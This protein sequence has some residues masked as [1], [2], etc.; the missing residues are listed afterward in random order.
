[1]TIQEQM[2]LN[3]K[4]FAAEKLIQEIAIAEKTTVKDIADKLVL[5][6]EILKKIKK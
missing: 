6:S 5:L 3:S 1:M 2:D 4:W